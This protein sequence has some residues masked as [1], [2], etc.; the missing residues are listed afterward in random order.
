MLVQ[1]RSPYSLIAPLS[2][3]ITGSLT[4]SVIGDRPS[5]AICPDLR[6]PGPQPK[7]LITRLKSKKSATAFRPGTSKGC[8][9]LLYEFTGPSGS[10][11]TEESTI[12]RIATASIEA[13]LVY[14]RRWRPD[15]EVTS[16]QS[17]GLVTLLSES[18]LD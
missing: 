18:P 1:G 4:P 9:A 15:F 12:E 2:A 7:S 10:G 3:L 6:L 11:T 14:L 5:H 13:G 17:L 8:E 16:V